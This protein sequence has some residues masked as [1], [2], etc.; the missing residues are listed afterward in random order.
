MF[1]VDVNSTKVNVNYKMVFDIVLKDEN[2][3]ETWRDCRDCFIQDVELVAYDIKGVLFAED[4]E[5]TNIF[6]I[7]SETVPDIQK[8]FICCE[9]FGND[10][11]YHVSPRALTQTVETVTVLY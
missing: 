6:Y 7:S 5:H 10:L 11:G 2:D 8:L 3:C 4:T 1:G 9:S